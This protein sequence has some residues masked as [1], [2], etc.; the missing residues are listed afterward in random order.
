MFKLKQRK[1]GQ[2]A[3]LWLLAIIIGLLVAHRRLTVI[4][5]A[6]VCRLGPRAVSSFVNLQFRELMKTR[7]PRSSV[8]IYHC[9]FNV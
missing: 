8:P 6:R 3:A 5:F 9:K 2:F 1:V 7:S 4:L